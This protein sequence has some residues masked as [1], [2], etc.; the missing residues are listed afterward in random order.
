MKELHLAHEYQEKVQAE[1]E[2]QRY[3]AALIKARAE[4]EVA[5]GAKQ[6]HLQS[7]IEELQ[8]RL[9]EAHTNKER[10]IAR[11]QMTRSGHVYIISNIGSSGEQVFK[12]GMTRQ[13]DPEDREFFR[14]SIDEIADAVHKHHG[15]IS[16]VAE[17]EAKDY[18]QTLAIIKEAEIKHIAP[19]AIAPPEALEES[20]EIDVRE[21]SAV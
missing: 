3:A 6:D 18:R 21:L 5:V 2:E 17:P 16:F 15:E 14:V 12:I 4:A 11:A 10:A 19:S 9:E 7:E 8:R 20:D 1:K 13:L